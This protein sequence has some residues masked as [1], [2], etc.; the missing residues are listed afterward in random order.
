MKTDFMKIFVDTA[1]FYAY[2]EIVLIDMMFTLQ[3]CQVV[4]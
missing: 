1:Q 3:Q 2:Q 4:V